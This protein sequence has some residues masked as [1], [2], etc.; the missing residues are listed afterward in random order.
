MEKTRKLLEEVSRVWLTSKEMHA[1]SKVLIQRAKGMRAFDDY[2]STPKVPRSV[3][4]GETCPSGKSLE[5][6]EL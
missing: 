4:G 5:A 3:E 2:S 1:L 6:R